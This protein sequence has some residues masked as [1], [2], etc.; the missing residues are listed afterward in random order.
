MALAKRAEQ[1]RRVLFERYDQLNA[2]WLEA[3][4]QLSKFHIP[5]PVCYEYATD[6]E[7]SG[8]H[9]CPVIG[10]C[11]G[12]QKVKGQ[13]RICYGTYFYPAPEEDSG[14]KPITECSAEVRVSAASHLPRFRER[15]VESAEEFIPKVDKAIT[16]LKEALEMPEESLQALLAERAKLNGRAK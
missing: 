14:W 13:W 7:Y 2:L 10:H 4:K 6:E 9:Y 3:E 5:C 8:Q 11:L 1:A 12:L 15:V 16:E